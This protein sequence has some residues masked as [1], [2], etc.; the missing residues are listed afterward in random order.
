M[1]YFDIGTKDRKLIFQILP[2]SM[3][4]NLPNDIIKSF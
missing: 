4:F 3:S 1:I 2:L